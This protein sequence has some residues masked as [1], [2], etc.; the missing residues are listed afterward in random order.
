MGK[1]KRGEEQVERDAK[2]GP[3]FP[4]AGCDGKVL[5][6]ISWP[7]PEGI[8]ALYGDAWPVAPSASRR[9]GSAA[10]PSGDG[11]L[12]PDKTFPS[13][14]A[15]GKLCNSTTRANTNMA[16]K[17]APFSMFPDSDSKGML[18]TN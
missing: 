12:M 15:D 17:F 11:Q 10:I 14:P 16:V 4:S 3:T 6:G 18:A 9:A 8:A 2:R 7:S 13:Q 5:S 1:K